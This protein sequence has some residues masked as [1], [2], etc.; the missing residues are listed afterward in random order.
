MSNSEKLKNLEI[1]SEIEEKK[2]EVDQPLSSDYI[3]KIFSLENEMLLSI[4]DFID[5]EIKNIITNKIIKQ[6][7]ILLKITNQ[8]L[9]IKEKIKDESNLLINNK[10]FNKKSLNVNNI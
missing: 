6:K 3:N 7:N 2:S 4:E 9:K 5:L 10:Y 8:E 1:S